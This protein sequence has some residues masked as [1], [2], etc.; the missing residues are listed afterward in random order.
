MN[1]TRTPDVFYASDSDGNYVT[2]LINNEGQVS[3]V[4]GS[5][6]SID[7]LNQETLTGC[8]YFLQLEDVLEARSPTQVDCYSYD[9]I[10]QRIGQG[11]MSY[12]EMNGLENQTQENQ[13]PA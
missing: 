12:L 5:V 13:T 9:E 1:E 2:Y 6:Q 8:E 11:E 10:Q 3:N 4:F 7:Q